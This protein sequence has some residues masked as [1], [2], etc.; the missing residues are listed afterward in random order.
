MSRRKPELK[1]AAA[2]LKRR[3]NRDFWMPDEKFFAQALDGSKRQVRAITSNPGH[4]L[5]MRAVDPAKAEHVARRLAFARALLGLGDP[6]AFG[7]R[8]QL[9]PVQLPQRVGVAVRHRACRRRP[10]PVRL[11]RG[12]GA[13]GSRPGRSV[14]RVS[15]APAAGAVLRG[16]ARPGRSTQ[17]LLEHLH[18][19]AVVGGGDVH[20]RVLDP[21]AGGRSSRQ[22]AARRAHP[23]HDVEP[24]RGDRPPLRGSAHRSV[25]RRDRGEGPAGFRREY[26]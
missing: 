16:A 20:V 11:R 23:H 9:R 1:D 21:R 26:A 4:C 6:H 13:R 15:A 24:D 25:R 8:G 14:H 3:F 18:P 17:G 7:A 19:A 5:W 10:A 22:G 12:G 2:Q